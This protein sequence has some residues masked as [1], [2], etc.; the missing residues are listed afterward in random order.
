MGEKTP[1][2]RKWEKKP[3]MRENGRKNPKW[4]K[5]PNGSVLG[6]KTF[7]ANRLSHAFQRHQSS[8]V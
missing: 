5:T 6:R 4:K 1:N 8:H 3:Q 2:E 7:Y